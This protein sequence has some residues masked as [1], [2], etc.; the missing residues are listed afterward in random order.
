MSVETHPPGDG[1]G[2]RVGRGASF[3]APTA[4]HATPPDPGAPHRRPTGPERFWRSRRVRWMLAVSFLLSVFVHYVFSPWSFLPGVSLEMKDTEGDLTI[5]IELLEGPASPP[6]PEPTA[7]PP[8]E[9]PASEAPKGTDET[10]REAGAPILRDGG[11]L[12][13]AGADSAA[14]DAGEEGG[15]PAT[16]ASVALVSDAAGTGQAEGGALDAGGGG[17]EFDGSIGDGVVAG[18]TL[19]EIR[20]NLVVTR[21]HPVGARLGPLFMGVPQWEEFLGGTDVDPVKD[22][23]WIWI[24]GPS[25]IHTEKDAVLLKYNMSD[26]RAAKNIAVLSK[27]DVGGG[28]YDAGTPGVRAWRAHADKAWRVFMLPR[29]HFAAMV[30]PD[31]AKVAARAFSKVEPRNRLGPDE[32]VRVMV[33]NPSHPMPFLPASLT[34]LRLWVVPRADGGA[35]ANVECDAPDPASAE[36]AEKQIRRFLNQTNSIGVR[37]MTRGILNDVEVTTEGA[38]VKAHAQASQDQLEAIY[39]LVAGF[40]GVTTP[41]PPSTTPSPAPSSQRRSPAPS[42]GR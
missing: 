41:P 36:V 31:F 40:L 3:A 33:K 1:R 4:P 32:A 28:A 14:R 7:T 23:D 29:P 2:G 39:D 34:E 38:T 9:P 35:D 20:M 26:A 16:D 24:F 19:V 22:L 8:S 5:P 12:R 6:P 10:G 30:P 15:E 37:I 42:P 13:D 17:G 21:S 18:T 25:L 27:H 11:G